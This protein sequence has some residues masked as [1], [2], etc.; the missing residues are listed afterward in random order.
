MQ[1]K[2][3]Q[4]SP[5]IVQIVLLALITVF[6]SCKKSELPEC[7]ESVKIDAYNLV[8]NDPALI[9]LPL[10]VWENQNQPDPLKV[11]PAIFYT[12][13]Q[14]DETIGMGAA[15]SEHSR[16]GR[17]V[18][19]VLLTNGMNYHML[20]WI[21]K[22]YNQAANMQ[23]VIDARNREFIAA[24]I[25]LGA[26]R[27]YIANRGKGYNDETIGQ[28]ASANWNQTKKSFKRTMYY[29]EKKFP[30]AS[31]KTISGNCDSYNKQGKKIPSHQAAASAL[32]D[33]YNMGLISD[34]RLYRVYC[35]Y[36]IEPSPDK[37]CNY[38]S[39]VSELDKK[40]KQQAI[41]QYRYKNPDE[42]RY[43]LGYWSVHSLFNNAWD[44][45]YEYV[46]FIESDYLQ[47]GE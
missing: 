24:C 20:A 1:E 29:F 25:E 37:S 19:V 26:H 16:E 8:V 7:N 2:E 35:F 12:P 3:L 23:D 9:E 41:N 6:I 42:K 17:P 14:D 31:H 11:R 30:G 43:G 38:F 10:L 46:D 45:N 27:I 28:C 33:L 39:P 22:K 34:A 36:Y 5:N 21:R 44:A 13:H 15:I 18:Y 4:I 40:I 32:H 47:G